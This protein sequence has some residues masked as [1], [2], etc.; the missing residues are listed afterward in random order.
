MALA[1]LYAGQP[2]RVTAR[3]TAERLLSSFRD[4]TLTAVH[5]PERI[6]RHVTP[7]TPLQQHILTL[8]NFTPAIYLRLAANSAQPP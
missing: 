5:L 8:L 6:V 7:L 4:I 2:T 3:P 1:G